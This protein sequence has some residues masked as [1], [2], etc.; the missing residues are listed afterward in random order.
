[1][2]DLP[3]RV[4]GVKVMTFENGSQQLLATNWR[5]G[6]EI[7]SRPRVQRPIHCYGSLKFGKHRREQSFCFWCCMVSKKAITPFPRNRTSPPGG[8]FRFAPLELEE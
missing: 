6:A 2:Q 8:H 4:F 1:M 5:L 3:S 7:L